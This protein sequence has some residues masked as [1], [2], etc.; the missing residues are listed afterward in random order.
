M[1]GRKYADEYNLTGGIASTE[2][3]PHLQTVKKTKTHTSAPRCNRRRRAFAPFTHNM[4]LMAFDVAERGAVRTAYPS[5]DELPLQG[6]AQWTAQK[7]VVVVVVVARHG[8]APAA[9][10]AA[11]LGAKERADFALWAARFDEQKWLVPRRYIPVYCEV[12]RRG[13]ALLPA[14]TRIDPA[15]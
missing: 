11:Y 13:C 9:V 15:R 12:H 7:A 8:S 14:A 2:R 1:L 3:Q 10:A 5:L 6:A 4:K